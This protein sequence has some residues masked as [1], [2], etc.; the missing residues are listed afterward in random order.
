MATDE[1]SKSELK[2]SRVTRDRKP[3]EAKYKPGKKKLT[4]RSKSPPR[5]KNGEREG[6]TIDENK[7]QFRVDDD[8][9]DST[10]QFKRYLNLTI[11]YF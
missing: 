9:I 2:K 7:E 6:T 8:I 4:G 11:L 1:L 10:W 5:F 3:P